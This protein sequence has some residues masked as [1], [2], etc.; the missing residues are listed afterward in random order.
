M[1]LKSLGAVALA[2]LALSTSVQAADLSPQAATEL[3][4][5]SIVHIDTKAMEALNAYLR[6][7]RTFPGQG[8]FINVTEMQEV[9]RDYPKELAEAFLENVQLSAADKKALEPAAVQ[10][11]A[12]VRE[13]QKRIACTMGQPQKVT[14]GVPAEMLAV[15]VPFRC[16]APNPPEKIVA[17]FQRAGGAKWNL[18]QYREG[19]QTLSEGFASAPLTQVWDGEFPLA[20]E[21]KKKK[22]LV[23]QNNFPRESI[24]VT[25]LQ[26]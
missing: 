10:L 25:P 26:Y 1:Q 20:A 16:M 19:M 8:D 4:L 18:A 2:S 23:W 7:V 21:K 22:P 15:N 17:F 5:K 11:F 14:E 3:F 6:P 9:D 13:S 24:D 12:S